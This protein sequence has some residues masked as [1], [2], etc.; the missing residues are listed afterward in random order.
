[1]M[2]VDNFKDFNDLYGHP[3]GDRCLCAIA[4]ITVET[5]RRSAVLEQGIPHSG[6]SALVVTVSIGCATMI[7]KEGASV[8]EI[9][10]ASDAALYAAKKGGRNRVEVAM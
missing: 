6:S 10:A 3:E 8:T 9:V 1:M 5:S 4:R 2:D 7:P